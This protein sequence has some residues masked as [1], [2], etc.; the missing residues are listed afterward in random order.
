[1]FKG[2]LRVFKCR[3]VGEAI[4]RFGLEFLRS[5][6]R[7]HA[8]RTRM[9]VMRNTAVTK[10][11]LKHKAGMIGNQQETTLAVSG[12]DIMSRLIKRH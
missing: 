5:G 10:H 7:V 1:M 9:V 8:L 3:V 2:C 6:V 11:E 4:P 12:Q